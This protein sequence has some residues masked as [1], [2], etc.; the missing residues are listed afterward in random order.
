[1]AAVQTALRSPTRAPASGNGHAA[2]SESA[3]LYI[4]T[5]GAF[6]AERLTEMLRHHA[7]VSTSGG[8]DDEGTI[9]VVQRVRVVVVDSCAALMSFLAGLEELLVR[10]GTKLVILD[11]MA[12]LFRKEFDSKSLQRRVEML[13][14]AASSLKFV[15]EQLNIPVLV[16]NQVTTLV[17]PGSSSEAASGGSVVAPALGNTWAHSVNTRVVIEYAAQVRT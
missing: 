1:M 7:D 6:S 12:S 3:V 10:L 14:T 15:A 8:L 16:T 11:S 17:G 5:E 2:G 13:G 4:D 9:A